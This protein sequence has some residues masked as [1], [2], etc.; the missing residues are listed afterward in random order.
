MCPQGAMAT[1]SRK[2]SEDLFITK[3]RLEETRTLVNKEIAGTDTFCVFLFR[4][5]KVVGTTG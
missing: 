3:K 2:F 1:L 5:V 4:I